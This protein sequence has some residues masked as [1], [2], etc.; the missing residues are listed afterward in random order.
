MKLGN[1]G[2]ESSLRFNNMSHY[3]N[4]GCNLVIAYRD[5]HSPAIYFDIALLFVEYHFSLYNV[6]HKD[7]E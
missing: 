7:D 5:D 6:N 1:Y 3:V 4:L 2:I